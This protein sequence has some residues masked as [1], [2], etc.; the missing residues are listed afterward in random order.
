MAKVKIPGMII[1]K[2]HD[3]FLNART[4]AFELAISDSSFKELENYSL[5]LVTIQA[6]N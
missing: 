2:I 5:V 6:D 4:S 1:C 3:S